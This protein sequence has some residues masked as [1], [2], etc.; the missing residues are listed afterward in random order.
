VLI[1]PIDYS[2]QGFN[3]FSYDL[4]RSFETGY[5]T[6]QLLWNLHNIGGGRVI[7]NMSFVML[8]CGG[9]IWRIPVDPPHQPGLY[10]G[11]SFRLG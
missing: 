6:E 8:Q 11:R 10:A 3:G 7:L 5:L 9:W 4:E 1:A 2:G